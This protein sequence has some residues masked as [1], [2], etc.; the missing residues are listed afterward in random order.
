MKT[1]LEFKWAAG[2]YE[3]FSRLVK[4]SRRFG[5]SAGPEEKLRNRDYYV[6]TPSATLREAD[7]VARIR[8]CGKRWEFTYKTATSFR[9][10]MAKRGEQTSRLEADTSSSAL[11]CLK[12]GVLRPEGLAL[13]F[14]RLGEIFTID[15]RRYQRMINIPGGTHALASFDDSKI[16]VDDMEGHLCEIEFEFVDGNEQAFKNFAK[17]VSVTAE[18][19][20]GGMS[21][22]AAARAMQDGKIKF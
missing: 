11:K 10:G 3:D 4:T 16:N 7:T 2:T 22:V 12:S 20:S 19:K 14:E 15:T 13:P 18:L 9:G 17:K 1:E 6:D 8:N 21:K 5:A